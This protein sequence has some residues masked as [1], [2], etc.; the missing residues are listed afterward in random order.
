MSASND[1]TAT[2]MER[3]AK[4]VS[5]VED[6]HR[7][8]NEYY[9]RFRGHYFSISRTQP[10]DDYWFYVYP[11]WSGTARD[12]A[13][14]F[15]PYRPPEQQTPAYVPFESNTFPPH[16]RA[17]FENLFSAIELK[18]SGVDDIFSMILEEDR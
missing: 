6:V 10:N 5:S 15:D 3:I 2:V 14:N 11:T 1:K 18:G 17:C 4:E 7:S 12:L 8:D 13:D 16:Q 9:F